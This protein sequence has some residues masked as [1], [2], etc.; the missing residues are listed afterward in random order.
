MIRA[1]RTIWNS[2]FFRN[3]ATLISGTSL[4]QAFSVV[5][6]I[7][8]SRIFS[9]E[10]FGAEEDEFDANEKKIMQLA[11]KPVLAVCDAGITSNRAVQSLRKLGLES[12]YGLKGGI[13]AWTQANLPLVTGKKT[14]GKK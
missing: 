2:E 5:I 3:V 8:L 6:Y 12:V 10:D 9:E 1:F 11:K 7:A 13:T 4:A 14:K